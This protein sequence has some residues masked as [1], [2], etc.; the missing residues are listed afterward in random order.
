M[1]RAASLLFLVLFLC[2]PLG[3]RLFAAIEKDLGQSLHYFRVT[4]PRANKAALVAA[5]E[6]FPALV[7]DL[8]TANAEGDFVAAL[9]A[10]LAQKPVG[11]AARFV[12]VNAATGPAVRAAL[13]DD[14]LASVI[15]LGPKA[16]NLSTDIPVSTSAEEDTRA[17]AALANGTE[18]EK[19]IADT[20]EKRRYDEAKLVQD[21]VNG[22]GPSSDDLPADADDDSIEA[23]PSSNGKN[24]AAPEKKPELP[25]R[26]LVLER[27]VQLHRALLALKKI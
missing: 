27:A 24:G 18:L 19:L 5:I 25:P 6:K 4:D 14:A 15:T 2:L 26:D 23:E 21:H 10:A 22:T 3:S 20:V 9:H 1:K 17:F 7:L 8:R 13:D 16:K 11:S 12:L